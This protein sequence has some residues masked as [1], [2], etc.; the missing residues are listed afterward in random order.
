MTTQAFE[1]L[2]VLDFCWVAIGPMTTRYLADHGAKVVKVESQHRVETLRNG[3]P[4]KDDIPGVNRSGY[5]TN[6]NG[7]KY[8]ITLNMTHPRAVEQVK[9]FVAWADLVTENFTP[10]TME[11][12]GLGYEDLKKV[13]PDIILFSASMLGRGGPN[14]R[15]PGFGGVLGSMAG[16]VNLCGWPDRTPVPPYAAYTDFFVPRFAVAAIGAAL[17]YRRRTGRGQHLDMSQLEAALH[18]IAPAILDYTV[19]GNEQTRAGNRSSYAAPHNAYPCLGEDRWCVIVVSTDRQWEALCLTMGNPAW[20][21]EERFATHLGRKE[22]EV[23]LDELIGRWTAD[24]EPRKLMGLL[25][26]AGVPAGEVNRC[27]DLFSDPQLAHRNHFV[28]Q[29]HP[30]IGRHASDGNEFRLPASPPRYQWPAPLL[31]EHTEYVFKEFLG[32][33]DQEYSDLVAE[34][35]LE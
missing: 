21:R 17:D 16:L 20:C 18:F 29:E 2:K 9:R 19:N 4:F 35:V 12:W 22:H 24:H 28:F 7:N 6:Y 33:S 14:D 30:E 23:D 15:Q 11:R 31:G 5:F 34:G 3:V 25:Q 27:E 10:G 1:G 8:G 26:E 32:V 13:N